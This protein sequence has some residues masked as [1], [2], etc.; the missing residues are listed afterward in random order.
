VWA[1]WYEFQFGFSYVDDD[2]QVTLSYRIALVSG[3]ITT[4]LAGL[5]FFLVFIVV[6]PP[7]RCALLQL[8]GYFVVQPTR[9]PDAMDDPYGTDTKA[10]KRKKTSPKSTGGDDNG[11][12]SSSST[13]N[14][15]FAA[16]DYERRDS[17]LTKDRSSNNTQLSTSSSWVRPRLST[18][19]PY[20]LMDEDELCSEIDRLRAAGPAS[21]LPRGDSSASMSIL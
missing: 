1:S 5:G 20:D 11:S 9:S 2:S 8:M 7:A 4:P 6:S 17:A 15:P 14:T 19:G 16:M 18:E 12:T 21:V 10:T 3:S 13:L